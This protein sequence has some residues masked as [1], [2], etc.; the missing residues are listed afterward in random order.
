MSDRTI[1]LIIYGEGSGSL[2]I[3]KEDATENG[4]A[5]VQIREGCFYEYEIT[6]G[7]SLTASDIVTISKINGSAGRIIPNV[8]VGNLKLI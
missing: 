2:L 3:E 7:Y 4:E 6:R 5:T 1:E 8:Y